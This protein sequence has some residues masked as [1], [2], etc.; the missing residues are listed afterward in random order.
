M[1]GLEFGIKILQSL[2]GLGGGVVVAIVIAWI[3]TGSL[4]YP[5]ITW[6]KWK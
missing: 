6:K 4:C 3:L 2:L 5:T 1:T